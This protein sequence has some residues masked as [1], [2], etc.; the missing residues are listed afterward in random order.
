MNKATTG[1][2]FVAAH[3]PVIGLRVS[4][5]LVA[6]FVGCVLLLALGACGKQPSESFYDSGPGYFMMLADGG[7]VF[8]PGTTAPDASSTVGL[9]LPPATTPQDAASDSPT[10][11]T[12]TT[13]KAIG[14]INAPDCQ[15]CNFPVSGAPA[16]NNA[17]PINIVYPSD[18][19]ILPPNLNVFS[20]QWTPF[21]GG[22]QTFSVDFTSSPN[23]D[24]HVLT[25]CSNQTTDEQAGNPSGG[26]ELVL[27]AVTWS[28]LVE[29][30][31]DGGPVVVTV[32]GTTDGKCASSS[33]TIHINFAKEDLLGT[34]YYWKSTVTSLGVGGQIWMKTFG[35]LNMTEQDVTSNVQG[36]NG[37]LGA[38]CNGCHALSRDGSRMVMYSDDSDS[39]DEYGDMGGSFL[40][41]TPIADG[42][43]AMELGDA[44]LPSGSGL[45]LGGQPPGFS[46]VHP[47]AT[48]YITSNG[49]PQTMSGAPGYPTN[50]GYPATVPSNGFS[51]WDSQGNFSGSF[52]VGAS[53]D[54]PT[55]PDWSIDGTS[56][57]YVVPSSVASWMALI[58]TRTDDD[59]VF[60][61]SLYTVPY[62][63]NG[64]FGTP[65]PFLMSNGENNYY[66]SYS[67]DSTASAA[68]LTPP[69]FVLFN[70]VATDPAGT[71]CSN[72]FC[73]NDSFSNPNAR[74]MLMANMANSTP[75]DLEKAN[76]SPVA[77]PVG[78]SNSYPRWAPFVQVYHG[79]KILWFTFSSTRD[80]GL[81]ILNHKSGMYQCYPDDAPQRPGGTHITAFDPTCQQPQI[82]MA[83]V[84]FSEARSST[85]DP[86][87]VAF[88]VPYQDMTTH[89]HTAQWTWTPNPPPPPTQDSGPPPCMCSH[90]YGACGA[91]NP[92]GCCS[93][94]QL[95]CSGSSQCINVAN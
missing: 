47:N 51:I 5:G 40:D 78:L 93:G 45:P 22:Y 17:A 89:N 80:Y 83:P 64:M 10:M 84:V 14:T 9:N 43:N 6:A 70:R 53:S 31:R 95:K 32:R 11:V 60:G 49:V 41:M 30:N 88:W 75:I 4:R 28:K 48:S 87:G 12:T 72:G 77:S 91:Q 18:T 34:Y 35:D 15:G 76:G 36:A 81:R 57:V 86:S 20:I 62:S 7:K 67:P 59:H 38:S 1:G 82:W 2:R 55:M 39:D 42:G 13:Q 8:V 71:N 66:P 58:G 21:G 23:T 19:V 61:G 73:P 33:S 79:N 92:C 63:G 37:S 44:G 69:S 54:R 26:C 90:V 68:G 29:A 65:T 25:S 94:E 56:V 3:M 85:I 74:L 52:A 50:S 27:D 24:W 46:T 16:C